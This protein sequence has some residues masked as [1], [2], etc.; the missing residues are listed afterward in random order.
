MVQTHATGKSRSMLKNYFYI[1]KG[2]NGFI[3]AIVPGNVPAACVL[4]RNGQN[5]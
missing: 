4:V 5:T 3:Y 2:L 1:L